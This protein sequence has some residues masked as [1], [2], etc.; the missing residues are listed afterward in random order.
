MMPVVGCAGFVPG[1]VGAADNEVAA[2]SL[3]AIVYGRLGT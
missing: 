2:R 3:D 1:A